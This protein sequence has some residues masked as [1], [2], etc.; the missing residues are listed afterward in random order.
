MC[1][2][3]IIH[4]KIKISDVRYRLMIEHGKIIK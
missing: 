4:W 1:A 2:P 3:P